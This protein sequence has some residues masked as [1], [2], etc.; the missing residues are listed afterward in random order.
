MTSYYNIEELKHLRRAL[1][2][3]PIPSEILMWSVLRGRKFM[4]YKFRR[5]YGI[6]R[7]IIDF[8]CPA[9]QLAVEIDGASHTW[10]GAAERDHI[11]QQWIE[12]QGIT[13]VRF[14]SSDVMKN[15]DGAVQ[16]L[17]EV[18]KALMNNNP[19]PASVY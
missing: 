5:Q 18:V 3:Q 7:Y 14:L 9:L 10:P 6:G 1:R 12:K 19:P 2:N 16:R 15:L 8:Y 4:G 11:R 13:V 17:E